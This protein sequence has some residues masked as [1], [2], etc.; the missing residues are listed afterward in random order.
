MD[1]QQQV[2]QRA[3]RRRPRSRAV[4]IAVA[5]LL[6]VLTVAVIAPQ[7]SAGGQKHRRPF[8]PGMVI[9]ESERTAD[10]TWTA[11]V[12]AL[13]ANPNI[14]LIATIDHS[15]AAASVDL[16]LDFNRVAVFGNPALG[17]PLMVENQVAGLD[18]PQKIQVFEWRGRVWI[19]FNDTTYLAARHHLGDLPQLDTIAGALRTLT[20]V[21]IDEEVDARSFGSRRF[22]RNPATITVPSDDDVE[23]TYRRLVAAIEAS[24]ANIAFEVDHQAGAEG[25]GIDLRPT[26]LV[27]FGNP[28][29]GTPLMQ[30]RPTAGIDLPLKFLVWEDAD[31]QTFVTTN[32]ES[33]LKK[34]HRIRNRAL[35]P[36]EAALE[37]FVT[38]ATTQPSG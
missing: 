37:N 36:V 31:G 5:W 33:L 11:L 34:R 29:L 3:T 2:G 26:R 14:N 32:D 17:S 15:A 6:M 16:E 21:A 4:R 12:A 20:G 24:P 7:A 18:L 28:Q 1:E 10:E 27:V 19:G 25:A 38:A 23:T 22:R 30:A 8:V 35:G 9:V 13:G